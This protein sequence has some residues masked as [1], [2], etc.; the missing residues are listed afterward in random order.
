METDLEREVTEVE[1]GVAAGS[2]GRAFSV[3]ALLGLS[4]LLMSLPALVALGLKPS[5]GAVF[6]WLGGSLA[7]VSGGGKLAAVIWGLASRLVA[8]PLLETAAA[9]IE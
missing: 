2:A 6:A 9:P 7:V 1:G 3:L 5:G 8:S 4:L